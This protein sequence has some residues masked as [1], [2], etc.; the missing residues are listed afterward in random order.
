M[1]YRFTNS[2]LRF[3]PNRGWQL[4]HGM[5][6]IGLEISKQILQR[7]NMCNN[8]GIDKGFFFVCVACAIVLK[9]V[10]KMWYSGKIPWYSIIFSV[11]IFISLFPPLPIPPP[12][13][14]S[15]SFISLW[16]CCM[17]QI[18][19]LAGLKDINRPASKLSTFQSTALAATGKGLKFFVQQWELP[20]MTASWTPIR[21]FQSWMIVFFVLG[22]TEEF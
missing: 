11:A 19:V 12:T 15:C 5:I 22:L 17:L 21:P 2:G 18:L 8:S 9:L 1:K 7:C 3:T 20:W 4:W 13:Y 6:K 16:H 14:P 10:S